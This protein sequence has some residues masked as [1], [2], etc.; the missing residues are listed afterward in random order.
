MF[1]I[2]TG[3]LLLILV[4]AVLV[5]GPEKMVEFAGKLGRFVAKLRQQ[6]DEVSREFREALS[7]DEVTKQIQ[8]LKGEIQDIQQ[9]ISSD[10]LL[11]SLEGPA[12]AA[13]APAPSQPAASSAT[14]E[15]Q[16]QPAPSPVPSRQEAV[17]PNLSPAA[18]PILIEAGQ[19]VLDEDAEAISI[20]PV[21][22]VQEEPR[23]P[24]DKTDEG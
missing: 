3:E 8:D 17:R 12:P 4:I 24:D 13:Q 11:E 2:G 7:V 14:V 21:E 18:E 19:A 23:S 15:E 9:G 20:E 10:R 1:G 5:I 16:P 6:S 22:I